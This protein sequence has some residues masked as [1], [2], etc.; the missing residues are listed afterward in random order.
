M[1]L[2]RAW[3]CMRA[4]ALVQVSQR[5]PPSMTAGQLAQVRLA[6]GTVGPPEYR[7]HMRMRFGFKVGPVIVSSSPRR[8][9]ASNTSG[10]SVLFVAILALAFVGW[11][12]E[13]GPVVAWLA[14]VPA[15][16]LVGAMAWGWLTSQ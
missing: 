3:S 2:P 5:V 8:R 15:A 12:S 9:P 6:L 13:A 7:R 1:L 4:L 11:A 16:L 14:A 10:G